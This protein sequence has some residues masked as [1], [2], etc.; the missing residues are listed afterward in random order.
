MSLPASVRA[1]NNLEQAHQIAEPHGHD[2]GQRLAVGVFRQEQADLPFDA[3][4]QFGQSRFD[5]SLEGFH[6]RRLIDPPPDIPQRHAGDGIVEIIRTQV[7][8]HDA[9]LVERLPAARVE[10]RDEF[11]RGKGRL[12]HDER[13]PETFKHPGRPVQPLGQVARIAG[14]EWVEG[15]EAFGRMPCR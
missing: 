6:R 1:G 14:I 12:T 11:R 13:S 4:D 5:G 2:G 9:G 15:I 3:G 10:E 8:R 7:E